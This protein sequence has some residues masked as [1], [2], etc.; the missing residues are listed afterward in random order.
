[1]KDENVLIYLTIEDYKFL[2]ILFSGFY[3]DAIGYLEQQLGTLER[4]NSST[5]QLDRARALGHL[6]DCYDAL[7]DFEEGTQLIEL[8]F[9]YLSVISLSLS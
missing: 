3:E 8:S 1:M 6:A 4:V 2:L 9:C 5:A 7:N